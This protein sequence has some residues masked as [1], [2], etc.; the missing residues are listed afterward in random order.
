[1]IREPFQEHPGSHSRNA[2]GISRERVG[3]DSGLTRGL[4]RAR[5]GALD[6]KGYRTK[7]P[8][9]DRNWLARAGSWMA[10]DAA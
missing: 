6:R 1:M 5:R 9:H 3:N 8:I 4:A 2:P 10:A 7:S